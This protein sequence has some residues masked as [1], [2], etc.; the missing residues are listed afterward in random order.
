MTK[1]HCAVLRCK[2][3]DDCTCTL[4]EIKLLAAPNKLMRCA[5]YVMDDDY[6]GIWDVVGQ[7]PQLS[8]GDTF[9]VE[10]D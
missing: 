4:H 9:C 3:N 6:S 7:N 10:A 1:I 8:R 5:D 2:H